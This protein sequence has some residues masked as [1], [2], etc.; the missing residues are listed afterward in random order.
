MA[1]TLRKDRGAGLGEDVTPESRIFRLGF[2]D[3]ES[4]ETALPSLDPLSF[5]KL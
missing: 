5:H 1:E 4:E 2:D 3:R